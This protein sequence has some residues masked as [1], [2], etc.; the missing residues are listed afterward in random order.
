[1]LTLSSLLKLMPCCV[2]YKFGGEQEET[3]SEQSE[4]LPARGRIEFQEYIQVMKDRKQCREDA[5]AHHDICHPCVKQT[6]SLVHILYYLH[7]MSQL[8]TKAVPGSHAAQWLGSRSSLLLFFL[9]NT[10]CR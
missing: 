1:M 4:H 10:L 8:L 5:G 7:Y 9:H 2:F 6:G 3:L